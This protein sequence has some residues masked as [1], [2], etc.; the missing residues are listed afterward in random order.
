[1][2]FVLTGEE[3]TTK[4]L[5]AKTYGMGHQV[6]H[7]TIFDPNGDTPVAKIGMKDFCAR[8]YYVLTNS[9]LTLDDPRRRL[10][11]CMKNAKLIPGFNAAREPGVQRVDIPD[12]RGPRS[13]PTPSVPVAT[14]RLNTA[15][16]QH[17]SNGSR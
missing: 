9:D 1:M 7:L 6:V 10:V 11:E 3:T 16:K 14:R 12:Y 4:N 2:S 13:K 8:V 5:C 17:D 15:I